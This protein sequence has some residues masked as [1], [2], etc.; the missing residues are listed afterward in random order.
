MLLALDVGNTNITLGLVNGEA[1]ISSR[2]AA[3]RAEM[4]ADELE[5]TIDAMLHLDG[6]SLADVTGICLG[7]V[8]PA[9]TAA[10]TQ[11]AERRG[12]PLLVADAATVPIS[13]RVPRPAEVGADRLVNALAVARLYGTPAVVVDFG[14]ATKFDC[15][16][17]D[18]AFVGG[19]IAPGIALGIEA[20]E[21]RTAKLPRIELRAP[22]A[23]IGTDTVSA[24]Q[25]GVVFGYRALTI[26]LLDRIKAELARSEK[27]E[28]SKIQVVLTG[29]LAAA[30]W[31]ADLPGVDAVD[32]ELTLKGLGLLWALAAGSPEMPGD[33]RV[34]WPGSAA[35]SIHVIGEKR[36]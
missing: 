15:V 33:D 18:G 4:T 21:A 10:A 23:A 34:S 5:T 12:L 35:G 7:S 9:L 32:V 6:A 26:G 20:L 14:T 19:A 1:V 16:A 25:S 24:I 27:V 17:R 30:P 11:V 2:R 36:K 22:D 8:V 29:G 31:A 28:A 3:T 13:I